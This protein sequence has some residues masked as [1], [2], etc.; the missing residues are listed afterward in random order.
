MRRIPFPAFL[1]CAL[2]A[3]GCGRRAPEAVIAKVGAAEITRD[4]FQ[5]RLSE[6]A[7][8]YQNYVLTPAGRR[9]F[10]E[11]LIREK[12]MLAAAR[13]A[14][15][16]GRKEYKDEVD[17]LREEQR[18]RLAEFQDYLLIKEWRDEAEAGA[19]KVS[20]DEVKAAFEA[21]PY[22][23]QL[24]HI[25][26]ADPEEGETLLKKI[27]QGGNFAALA[28]TNSLDQDTASDGGKLK[29]LLY[30]EVLPELKDVA[31]RMKVGEVT[32]LIRSKFG[33]HILR[34][35]GQR[36]VA[37]AAV[38]D[39]LKKILEKEKLDAQLNALQSR[40]PV[41]VVDAQFK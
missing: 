21:H 40:Y 25:L 16:A 15:I 38:Q 10:L 32:G 19:L 31:M 23:I 24:R 8:E 26:V 39:R 1:A 13:D 5:Q 17:K 6:V 29:P 3:G 34:K 33:Y 4:E 22:E 36:K 30:G 28:K 35:E 14:G 27:R 18:Q 20:D 11:I 37:L 2:A 41:E 9:Q 7:P 12:I